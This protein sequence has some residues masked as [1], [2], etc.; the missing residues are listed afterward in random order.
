MRHAT[1]VRF[2]GVQSGFEPRGVERRHDVV[3]LDRWPGGLLQVDLIVVLDLIAELL[4]PLLCS[5][6]LESCLVMRQAERSLHRAAQRSRDAFDAGQERNREKTHQPDADRD[7]SEE[8]CQ[9]AQAL[10]PVPATSRR[11][12]EYCGVR[13]RFSDSTAMIENPRNPTPL[14]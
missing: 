3:C 1:R 8:S 2:E 11:I 14:P 4:V 10:D 9:R 12:E 6:K 13:H 7:D 5:K